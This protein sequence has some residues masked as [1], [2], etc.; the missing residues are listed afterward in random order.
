MMIAP[1][2]IVNAADPGQAYQDG[3]NIA[4]VTQD[5]VDRDAAATV[6]A[7]IA[8]AFSPG[9]TVYDVIEAMLE[10]ST[11]IVYRG[12]D[13]ALGLAEES[14]TF[15][16]FVALFYDEL[17]DW[18]WPAVEWDREKFYRGEIFG[19]SSRELF[20]ATVGLLSLWDG[21]DPDR[22]IVEGANFGRDADTIA[23]L[24]GNVAGALNGAS[25]IRDEWIERCEE[26]NEDFFEEL[27]G[28]PAENF[29]AMASR[30]ES[31]LGAERRQAAERVATLDDLLQSESR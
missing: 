14:D 23:S 31:A 19:A 7:G 5:G 16:D 29:A 27:H 6:A 2:G 4:S 28:D 20:P 26:A 17:L 13:L 25:E 30:L 22:L 18:T 15:D 9:A 21:D 1:V 3:F 8:E 11:E 12:M 24:L 10:H